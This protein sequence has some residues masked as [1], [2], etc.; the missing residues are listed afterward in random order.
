M[1]SIRDVAKRAGV[2]AGTVSNVLN[3]PSYVAIETRQKV[4]DAIAELRFEPSSSARQFRQGRQRTLGLS[5]ADMGNP[6]FSDVALAADA[7]A[8]RLD[9]GVV[10]VV[11]DEDVRREEQ[12][13][14]LLVQQRVHG[15]I[16]TPV[17]EVNPRLEQLTHQGIPIVYVDRISGNRPC[18]WVRTDD[19][20]GGRLAGEHLIGR[21]HRRI[22][23][24]GG[25]GFSDQVERRFEGFSRAV[26]AGGRTA[27]RIQTSSWR[28]EDGSSAAAQ[29][30]EMPERERPT[31]VMCANDLI[32]LGMLQGLWTRGIRVPEDIA[33]VGFDDLAWAAAAMIPLTSVRQQRSQLG[34]RAVHMLL[35]EILNPGTHEHEHVVLEPKLV[36]RASTTP[37]SQP[38]PTDRVR[39]LRASRSN[40][41]EGQS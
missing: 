6:F 1:A 12:N 23:F 32:A 7:E 8:K 14:E 18:C 25:G 13:L 2:S 35:D 41:L 22:A 10:L 20:A 9:M 30:A 29:L 5:V 40:Q 37:D 21:G 31:A 38:Y 27:E 36:A 19:V 28:F 15:I 33:I 11:A 34:E 16:I 26:G 39:P 17:D 24:V 4:L 3:R